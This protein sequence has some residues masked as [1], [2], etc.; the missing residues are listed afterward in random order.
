LAEHPC[1]DCGE[2]DPVVLE[3]DHVRGKKKF[4]ISGNAYAKSDQELEKEIAKCEVRCR[5]CHV[6]RHHRDGYGHKGRPRSNE[7]SKTELAMAADYPKQLKLF[8]LFTEN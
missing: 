3:F 2:T 5:N 4:N 7:P 8:T 6:K 1:V